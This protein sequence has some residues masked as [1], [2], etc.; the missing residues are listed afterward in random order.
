MT[1]FQV[2]FLD[3][4]GNEKSKRDFKSYKDISENLNIGYHLVRDL[5]LISIGKKTK[6]FYHKDLQ[7]LMTKIKIIE[8]E[9]EFN[10]D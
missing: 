3:E 2:I 7:K 10:F 5:H 4:N 1:K 6:K 8:I 9:K